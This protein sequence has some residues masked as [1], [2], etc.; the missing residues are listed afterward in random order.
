MNLTGEA[1][2]GITCEF[3][4]KIGDVYARPKTKLPLPDMPG[5]LSYR[6]YRPAEGQQLFF[7]TFDDIPKRLQ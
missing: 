6:M 4:H 3:C 5:I 1:A 2:E 7:G